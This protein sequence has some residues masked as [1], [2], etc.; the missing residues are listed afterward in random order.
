M[1]LSLLG[2]FVWVFWIISL[3][4]VTGYQLQACWYDVKDAGGS[5]YEE[6]QYVI[7]RGFFMVYLI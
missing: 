2:V 5:V 7:K 3:P 4:E 1:I 6:I